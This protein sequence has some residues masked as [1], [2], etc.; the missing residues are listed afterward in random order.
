MRDHRDAKAMAKALREAF[1][2][3]Q[4]TITHSEALEIVARQ[5]GLGTWNI[6]SA[7]IDAA[8]AAEDGAGIAFEQAVPIVRIFDVAKAQEFYLGFLGFT[9][10]W[11]HRYGDDFPLYTQVSRSG[12]KLHLS[13][14]A[15][16]ATPGGNMCVYMRG[17]RAFHKELLAKNYRYMRPG[18]EDE[19]T[20]LELTVIDPF[21]NRIRFMEL[22]ER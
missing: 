17:I 13:E 20:R 19:G 16:D 5:F 10:D 18:L 2:E 7:K 1:A 11:E 3:N 21:N 4:V 6:L 12:L 15:G 8:G 9:V 14:H 22:K